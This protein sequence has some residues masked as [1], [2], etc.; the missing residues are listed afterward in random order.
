MKNWIRHFTKVSAIV[1]LGLFAF[2]VH[3]ADSDTV[4]VKS[5]KKLVRI[6]RSELS[7]YAVTE[8][9]MILLRPGAKA[10]TGI[11]SW[12]ELSGASEA[13]LLNKHSYALR[14]ERL[15]NRLGV[16]NKNIT[17]DCYVGPIAVL[18]PVPFNDLTAMLKVVDVRAKT[19][20]SNFKKIETLAFKRGDVDY[21]KNYSAQ[22]MILRTEFEM[23]S[24]IARLRRLES[25][26]PVFWERSLPG[27]FE[28]SY[29]LQHL[30]LPP[31]LENGDVFESAPISDLPYGTPIAGR[32]GFI[33]SPYAAKH[34]LVDVTGL[35]TGM[36]IKCPYTGKLF[37]VPPQ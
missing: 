36:E 19:A 30:P 6:S 35:P 29:K 15:N 2:Y 37:R 7:D 26:G 12:G 23:Q 34:Q 16:P 28:Q 17:Y 3:A 25:L 9:R 8:W 10:Y 31:F 4:L 22:Y 27:L 33:N 21:A 11:E 13:E 32:P 20:D 5:D 14:V 1:F 24:E 18:D